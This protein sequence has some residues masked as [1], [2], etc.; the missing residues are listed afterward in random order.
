MLSP[1]TLKSTS[2]DLLDLPGSGNA[3][4]TLAGSRKEAKA[5]ADIMII[6][7]SILQGTDASDI[8]KL[9]SQLGTA[10][11]PP[12]LL[13]AVVKKLR[14][15]L[16]LF[17]GRQ[18]GFTTLQR[19]LLILDSLRHES[20]EH[21]FECAGDLVALSMS[22]AL[23]RKPDGVKVPTD[24]DRKEASRVAACFVEKFS[25]DWPELEVDAV[26]LLIKAAKESSS[27][28]LGEATNAPFE[29]PDALF[30]ALSTLNNLPLNSLS[31]SP[32]LKSEL[33][34]LLDFIAAGIQE[35]EDGLDAEVRVNYHKRKNEEMGGEKAEAQKKEDD[36]E[37]TIAEETL[38]VRR[39]VYSL[40]KK[41]GGK[42]RS[43]PLYDIFV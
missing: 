38:R 6:L 11:C 35:K 37:M 42:T 21:L 22:L 32:E 1:S 30:G 8:P 18:G 39:E 25:S 41:L 17:L 12:S 16:E 4:A 43:T 29:F 3:L 26:N 40:Q 27:T 19:I 13:R 24:F 10:N 28:V 7:K 36:L 20:N 15:E 5:L 9:L 34:K 14:S 33:K 2:K 31:S 23:H